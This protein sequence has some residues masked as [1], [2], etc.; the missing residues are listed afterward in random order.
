[1]LFVELPAAPFPPFVLPPPPPPPLEAT[2]PEQQGQR[3]PLVPTTALAP[4]PVPAPP[5]PPATNTG[6]CCDA[7]AKDPV[8]AYIDTNVPPPPPW[9]PDDRHELG[10]TPTLMATVCPLVKVYVLLTTAP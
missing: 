2:V 5:P 10:D 4:A 9:N 7:V 1:M 6:V 3:V 8:P